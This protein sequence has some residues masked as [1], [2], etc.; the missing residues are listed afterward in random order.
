[1]S[2]VL[3]PPPQP[4]DAVVEAPEPEFG[5]ATPVENVPGPQSDPPPIERMEPSLNIESDVDDPLASIIVQPPEP[6]DPN[7]V[8][9]P[10]ESEDGDGEIE[11]V[12]K[13]ALKAR[14]GPDLAAT[15][16]SAVEGMSNADWRGALSKLLKAGLEIKARP[17]LDSQT[18]AN[19]VVIFEAALRCVLEKN[20]MQNAS[21]YLRMVDKYYRSEAGDKRH[22]LSEES[23]ISSCPIWK[24]LPF[25]E[26]TVF[27]A[28]ADE[29]NKLAP[30]SS[31]GRIA[32]M[33]SQQVRDKEDE[34]RRI[35]FMQVQLIMTQMLAFGSVPLGAVVAF[36]EKMEMLEVV[37]PV[38]PG[39]DDSLDHL[40]TLDRV[41]QDAAYKEVTE[42]WPK[43]MTAQDWA[44]SQY[45]TDETPIRDEFNFSVAEQDYGLFCKQRVFMTTRID[46]AVQTKVKEQW[47]AWH[48]AH[49]ADPELRVGD[50]LARSGIPHDMRA[51]TWLALTSKPTAELRSYRGGMSYAEHKGQLADESSPGRSP[52]LRQWEKI[53]DQDLH[54]TFPGHPIIDSADGSAMLRRVLVSYANRNRDIGYCQSMN[55]IAAALLVATNDE[56]E[57][58]WLLALLEER[59][60]KEYHSRHMLGCRTDCRMLMKLAHQYLPN[61]FLHLESN[62][63]IPEVA[64]IHW[65]L[66][67][68]INALPFGTT[69]AV[70]DW[71]LAQT[72]ERCVASGRSKPIHV[73]FGEGPIGLQF[74]KQ[75]EPDLEP[76][77]QLL[78]IGKLAPTGQA[79]LCGLLEPGLTLT[80][81]SGKDVTKLSYNKTMLLMKNTPRPIVLVFEEVR[82]PDTE[83]LLRVA[84]ASLKI[85]ELPLMAAQ[86]SQEV[87]HVMRS[88]MAQIFDAEELLETAAN[89]NWKIDAAQRDEVRREI[90]AEQESVDINRQNSKAKAEDRRIV[91]KASNH[92]AEVHLKKGWIDPKTIVREP[93]AQA[94]ENEKVMRPSGIRSLGQRCVARLLNGDVV[95]GTLFLTSYR[96][97]FIGCTIPASP[98]VAGGA[99]AARAAAAAARAVESTTPPSKVPPVFIEVPLQCIESTNVKKTIRLANGYDLSAPTLKIVCKDARRIYFIVDSTLANLLQI[100]EQQSDDTLE[101]ERAVLQGKFR[102]SLKEPKSSSLFKMMGG[103][104]D[105][106]QTSPEEQDLMAFREGVE[107]VRQRQ[108]SVGSFPF[109]AGPS[110]CRWDDERGAYIFSPHDYDIEGPE[111]EF[112]RQGALAAVKPKGQPGEG[113]VLW[114]HTTLNES[115]VLGPTYPSYLLVP[116]PCSDQEVQQVAKFRSKARL[117]A[118][119]WFD[120]INHGDSEPTFAAIVR[121]AQPLVGITGKKS[122]YDERLFHMIAEA[123]PTRQP[124]FLADARPWMN[125]LANKG[126]SGGYEDISHYEGRATDGGKD[127]GKPDLTFMNIDNI[128]VMRD[129][130]KKM[131]QLMT[132]SRR[133]FRE[134]A[135]RKEIFDAGWLTHVGRVLGGTRRIVQETLKGR[136]TIVHCSDGWDRTAQLCAMSE[137]CLDPYYRTFDGFRVVVAREWH[138]FGHKMKDRIWGEKLTERS[139][140]FFQFFDCVHQLMFEYPRAFEFNEWYILSLLDAMYCNGYSNFRFNTERESYEAKLSGQNVE[141]W[142]IADGDNRA[143]FV[144]DRYDTTFT[145]KTTRPRPRVLTPPRI[146]RVW[147]NYFNRYIE[148]PTAGSLTLCSTRPT[149]SNHTLESIATQQ[150]ANAWRRKQLQEPPCKFNGWLWQNSYTGDKLRYYCF[151]PSQGTQDEPGEA[152]L[153]YFDEEDTGSFVP[154]GV[155]SL[156]D[157]MFTVQELTQDQR[158]DRWPFTLTVVSGQSENSP[159]FQAGSSEEQMM[160]IETFKRETRQ[161]GTGGKV[162]RSRPLVK[163]PPVHQKLARGK[164]PGTPR[165]TLGENMLSFTLYKGQFGFGVN[166]SDVGVVLDTRLYAEEAGIRKGHIIAAINDKA[167]ASKA[168]VQTYAHLLL[169]NKRAVLIWLCPGP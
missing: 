122:P 148:E 131:H 58:F 45:N 110:D 104:T 138:S 160:W 50:R 88:A 102:T 7:A 76:N 140:I 80:K 1:M 151:Y 9:S 127:I 43:G 159:L 95:G 56:E 154:K 77:P 99:E 128:H 168:D 22:Y 81:V 36:R 113:E 98:T 20:D 25:W 85:M 32:D 8:V 19:L 139:P 108:L 157:G 13:G 17:Y 91:A 100:L 57:S 44:T 30:I 5:P 144:N 75:A 21:V 152:S 158:I 142:A 71:L 16:K 15:L 79:K 96:L 166:V 94:A 135:R 146:A 156:P 29:R 35:G 92:L 14:D 123:N 10:F 61:V 78:T 163:A 106:D 155:I 101:N 23:A 120:G 63:I 34:E 3:S 165:A 121:C 119:S 125:A 26:G 112:R 72:R 133:N 47:E 164:T 38:A 82:P 89:P 4:V 105:D 130:L 11:L 132:S 136:S 62:Q 18:F 117:P 74:K 111:A 169:G 162:D 54:R 141:Y 83:L 68:F 37:K 145:G 143:Q 12:L 87:N 118:L 107:A 33:D 137:I 114:R 69:M 31:Q 73:T 147:V 149:A 134:P 150:P 93:D 103:V 129:S 70:W 116:R 84:L 48:E 51:K 39:G 97:A 46:P 90:I 153:V 40:N 52:D 2:G 24:S 65:F 109:Q 66:C 28:I 42:E 64:F 161:L 167:V 55:F 86:N 59:V 6:E 27:E 67:V 60:L 49:A 115:Y 126:K 41:L 124:L 53:I